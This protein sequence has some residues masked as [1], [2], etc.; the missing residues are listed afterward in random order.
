MG[1]AGLALA[2]VL[3]RWGMFLALA[4]HV[5]SNL[6]QFRIFQELHRVKP[7]RLWIGLLLP[8]W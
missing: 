4:L 3:V 7:T 8:A 6:Q 2:S 5:F 1:I